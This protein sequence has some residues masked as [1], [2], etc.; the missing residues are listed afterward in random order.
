MEQLRQYFRRHRFMLW[1]ALVP[2][3]FVL[4]GLPQLLLGPPHWVFIIMMM[5]AAPTGML[6]GLRGGDGH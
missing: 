6:W 4:F 2:A 3:S 5:L 1:L